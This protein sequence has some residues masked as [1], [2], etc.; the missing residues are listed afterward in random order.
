M[1]RGLASGSFNAP[2]SDLVQSVSH[3]ER[4]TPSDAS[5][6]SPVRHATK[7]IFDRIFT[8]SQSV[9]LHESSRVVPL[10]DADAGKHVDFVVGDHRL[11]FECEPRHSPSHVVDVPDTLI[12]EPSVVVV[13]FKVTDNGV[14]LTPEERAL[15]CKPFSQVRWWRLF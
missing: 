5:N 13:C 1:Q 3:G 9:R 2:I 7:R 12:A 14:G 10:N 15:L 11:P 6:N 4:A 8:P